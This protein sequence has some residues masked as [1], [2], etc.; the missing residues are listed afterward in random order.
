[1]L[2]ERG[3]RFRGRGKLR[4]AKEPERED[5]PSLSLPSAPALLSTPSG[6]VAQATDEAARLA[7]E[8]SAAALV[9]RKL[10]GLIVGDGTLSR[11]RGARGEIAVR[12]TSW[13]HESDPRFRVTVLVDVSD[14]AG[15]ADTRDSAADEQRSLVE[16]QRIARL[17]SWVYYP[18]TGELSCS[19][20]LEELLIE[21]GVDHADRHPDVRTAVSW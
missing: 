6:I 12:V 18:E 14:L 9:G 17:G 11:L 5:V 15:T 13:A 1:M 7:G 20:V 19:P 21:S 16:A 10:T 8:T 3:E 4:V 2:T